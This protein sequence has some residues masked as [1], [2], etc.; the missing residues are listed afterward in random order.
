[1][2]LA[3]NAYEKGFLPGPGGIDNQPQLFVPIMATISSA[4][5]DEDDLERNTSEK[6]KTMVASSRGSQG[7]QSVLNGQ[8]TGYAPLPIPKKTR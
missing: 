7:P 8:P 1:M 3:Y 4:I 2:I 5:H 6:R